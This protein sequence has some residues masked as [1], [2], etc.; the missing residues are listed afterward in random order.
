MAEELIDR[1]VVAILRTKIR[2]AQ[3]IRSRP[4]PP[5]SVVA[6]PRHV[7]LARRA[8]RES[9]VLLKNDGSLL[10]FD[11]HAQKR[12]AVVGRLADTPNIGD[13]KGSSHVY[14]PYVVTP[15]QGITRRLDGRV[16]VTYADGSDARALRAAVTDADAVVIVVGLTSD[17]EGEYIPH[18]DTGCG[19]DRVDL[20]LKESDA[21]LIR[22]VAGLNSRCVVVLQGGGAIMTSA[23]EEAVP[24]ILMT[25]YPGMEGGNALAELL[26]GDCSPSGKLPVTFARSADQLPFFDKDAD[27]ITYDAYHGYFLADREKHRVAYPFGFGL[28]YTRFSYDELRVSP[29]MVGVDDAVTVSVAVTNTGA[30]AGDEIVEI[31][32]S[33]VGSGVERHVKDLKGFG[34][35]HL[36]PGER[37]VLSRTLRMRDLAFYDVEGRRWS[38]EKIDYLVQVGPSSRAED[39]LTARVSVR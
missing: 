19:G 31:Y 28:S 18:W 23:W 36:E 39:L 6:G 2:F 37:R 35:L 7:E 10:P 16:S 21:R 38:V 5:R 30:R 32:V 4:C 9:A 25:W 15:L 29:S 34:R 11:E 12:I 27:R 26:Y 17:E 3:K 13:M 1:A 20:G 24:A 33:C 14:P 8:A 22:D